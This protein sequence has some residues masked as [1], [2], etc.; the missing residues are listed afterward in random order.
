[1]LAIGDQ[2]VS[3]ATTFLSAVLVGRSTTKEEFGSYVLGL[4][5]L[6]WVTNLQTAFVTSPYLYR[7]AGL[8]E[9]E[10]RRL[11]GSTLIHHLILAAAATGVAAAVAT[12]SF[13]FS[14]MVWALAACLGPTLLKEYGR[15]TS[16]AHGRPQDALVLDSVGFALQVGALGWLAQSGRVSPAAAYLVIGLASGLAAAGWLAA[17][18][19][20]FRPDPAVAPTHLA[21]NWVLGKWLFAGFIVNA[22]GKDMYG[23]VLT[24]FHGTEAAGVL[25]ACLGIVMLASPLAVG[26]SNHLGAS[27]ARLVAE[28]GPEP[29]LRRLRRAT[30]IAAACAAV[31]VAGVGLFGDWG[32]THLY[33]AQYGGNASVLTVLAL[34][35]GA[36]V[37]TLP[38]GVGLLA[39]QRA[40]LTF[41][42]AMAGAIATVVLGVGAA[43]TLGPL[44]AALGLV[45]A[46]AV[47]GGAKVW[48]FRRH[49]KRLGRSR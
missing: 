7:Q 17:Q 32:I 36:T 20:A 18:R 3:S 40:D 42:A 9:A 47:E 22:I 10:R 2:G 5:I 12:M 30:W 38:I 28:Q 21:D 31:F 13:R 48:L 46:N 14:T 26:I 6:A 35:L 11:A 34:S 33:G 25:A 44:G 19:G 4:T 29:L 27:Y 45:S 23:W 24:A 37:V 39:L 16:F 41:R 8:S 43:W 15:Q 1:M 49:L